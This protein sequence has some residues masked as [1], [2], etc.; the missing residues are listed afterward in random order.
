MADTGVVLGARERVGKVA[1]GKIKGDALT[2][3]GSGR[4][5]GVA[6]NPK[7]HCN[8]YYK[9]H[10]KGGYCNGY[11]RGSCKQ[12]GRL[13]QFE[14]TGMVDKE[15]LAG[16]AKLGGRIEDGVCKIAASKH[17]KV[18]KLISGTIKDSLTV[19]GSGIRVGGVNV[20]SDSWINSCHEDGSHVRCVH[21]DKV[22]AGFAMLDAD[23]LTKDDL[24]AIAVAGARFDDGKIVIEKAKAD[25]LV[26]QLPKLTRMN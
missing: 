12:D 22:A 20:A 21:S 13:W 3:A 2:V 18:M 17:D 11:E 8:V 1:A 7:A 25:A 24:K 19:T 23:K 5:A 4:L 6:N 9:T 26:K 15:F 16:F 10:C 14:Y